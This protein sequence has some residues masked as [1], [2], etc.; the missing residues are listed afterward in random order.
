MEIASYF[1]Y[2]HIEPTH[3]LHAGTSASLHEVSRVYVIIKFI[4]V[5]FKLHVSWLRSINYPIYFYN[6]SPEGSTKV[7][8]QLR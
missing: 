1:L 3:N 7:D 8:V 2:K 4:T 5:S 6:Y